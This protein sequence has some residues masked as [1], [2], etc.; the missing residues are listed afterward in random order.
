M[1][2]EFRKM[3]FIASRVTLKPNPVH[4]TIGA[5]EIVAKMNLQ[6][7]MRG[8]SPYIP[9]IFALVQ[10]SPHVAMARIMRIVSRSSLDKIK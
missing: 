4:Q 9:R 10:E 6:T 3:N 5:K 2:T 1:K 7:I 8:A